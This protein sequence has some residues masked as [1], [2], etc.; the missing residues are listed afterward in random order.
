VHYHLAP[1]RLRPA[2][3]LCVATTVLWFAGVQ[4]TVAAASQLTRLPSLDA[5]LL[6]RLNL[7][8]TAH[9]LPPLRVNARLCTAAREHSSEM[10]SDGYFAHDSFDGSAFWQRLQHYYGVRAVGENLLWS[11]PDVTARQAV[12]RWMS[13]PEHRATILMRGWREIG[14][15]AA[16]TN[17]APGVYSG[18]P[19]TVVTADFGAGR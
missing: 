18:R 10:L 7:I 19:V 4:P 12:L 13:S 9:G 5:T 1:V 6:S 17:A 8:R 16:R 11:S 3:L 15:A 2:Q 14:I